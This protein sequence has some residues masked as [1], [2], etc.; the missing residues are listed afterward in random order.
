MAPFDSTDVINL[1]ATSIKGGCKV[2]LETSYGL[3]VETQ[4]NGTLSLRLANEAPA[5]T[6]AGTES[7]EPQSPI[8]KEDAGT[9]SGKP[10]SPIKKED[11]VGFRYRIF[12]DWGTEFVWWDS[13]WPGNHGEMGL[14]DQDDI[15]ERYTGG[16]AFYKAFEAWED[17]YNRQFEAQEC[18]LSSQGIL[19]PDKEEERPWII[20]GFLLAAWL[21][22]QADVHSIEYGPHIEEVI[23]EKE[24]L[25]ATTLSFMSNIEEVLGK[26]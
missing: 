18:H 12:P 17:T 3:I 16:K 22:L 25:A 5:S 6:T 11:E 23:L 4:P 8:K 21:A 20:E 24:T 13:S 19:W 1:L 14:V 7:E 2:T 10:Q 15:E 9:E 26:V